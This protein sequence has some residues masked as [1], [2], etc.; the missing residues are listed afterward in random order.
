MKKIGRCYELSIKG[1]IVE[2]DKISFL[3]KIKSKSIYKLQQKN[4]QD[5]VSFFDM[6][7]IEQNVYR[8]NQYYILFNKTKDDLESILKQDATEYFSNKNVKIFLKDFDSEERKVLNYILKLQIDIVKKVKNKEIALVYDKKGYVNQE[9]QWIFSVEGKSDSLVLDLATDTDIF[10]LLQPY[11]DAILIVS[12][13]HPNNKTFSLTDI[14][15][16]LSEQNIKTIIAVTNKSIF[17]LNKYKFNKSKYL[18]IKN[19]LQIKYKNKYYDPYLTELRNT[20]LNRM[21]SMGIEFKEVIYE[22]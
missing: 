1:K 5:L 6:Q 2:I 19:E 13:N 12:H 10:H 22:K 3:K 15:T 16:F 18:S 14:E 11:A 21:E 4:W 17:I 8:Y 9:K 7:E 20:W